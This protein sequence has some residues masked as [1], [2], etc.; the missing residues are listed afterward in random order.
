M[1]GGKRNLSKNA[2]QISSLGRELYKRLADMSGHWEKVGKSLSSAVQ[3]YNRAMGSLET[4]VLVSARR[5]MELSGGK[6]D[7]THRAC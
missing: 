3:A 1:D 5:F 4:R 7:R 6:G 2:E